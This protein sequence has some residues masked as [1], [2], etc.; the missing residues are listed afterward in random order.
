MPPEVDDV[1]DTT[2]AG[3]AFLGGLIVGKCGQCF[4]QER[5]RRRKSEF[6]FCIG[7]GIRRHGIPSTSEEL[8]FVFAFS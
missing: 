6:C 7:V 4:V 3:D 8:R 2:G 5:A 1:V